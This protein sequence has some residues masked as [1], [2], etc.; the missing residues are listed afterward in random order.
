MHLALALAQLLQRV[1][2]IGGLAPHLRGQLAQQLAR[3]RFGG[4]QCA[5]RAG[6]DGLHFLE[7]GQ[8][9]L[10]RLLD[11]VQV[12]R[13]L[14]GLWR[15]QPEVGIARALALADEVFIRRARGRLLAHRAGN[16]VQVGNAAHQIGIAHAAIKARA[17]PPRLAAGVFLRG[18]RR[19]PQLHGVYA[20][21]LALRGLKNQHPPVIKPGKTVGHNRCGQPLFN[22]VVCKQGVMRNIQMRNIR[23]ALA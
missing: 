20:R 9:S 22:Q 11:G 2:E 16:A 4:V 5:R 17:V 18:K 14:A 21:G 13:G 19:L 15:V 12:L 8:R 7:L 6:A 23:V 3:F 1:H 10:R